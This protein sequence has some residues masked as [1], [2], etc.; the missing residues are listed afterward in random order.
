MLGEAEPYIRT[1][2]DNT[3]CITMN[4]SCDPPTMI[5][6]RLLTLLCQLRVQSLNT[7]TLLLVYKK[8]H[9]KRRRKTNSRSRG[10]PGF[11]SES[12][13]DA[14]MT[15]ENTVFMSSSLRIKLRIKV[16]CNWTSVF[17]KILGKIEHRI[18]SSLEW[19]S[20]YDI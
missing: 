6:K 15:S 18:Y 9:L 8:K 5:N 11:G 16:C 7:Q 13:G 17:K 19:L 4:L 2:T 3:Q 14:I 1:A 10:R 12:A 20:P